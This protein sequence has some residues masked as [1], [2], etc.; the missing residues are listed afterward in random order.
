MRQHN[1]YATQTLCCR[2]TTNNLHNFKKTFEFSDF[3]KE[4]T[5]PLKMM[6]E[7]CWSV[8]KCFNTDILD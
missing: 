8:F 6:I 1:F 4:P 3:N 5:T 2:I 7:K